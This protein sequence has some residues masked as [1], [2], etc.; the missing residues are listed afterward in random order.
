MR[1]WARDWA[2]LGLLFPLSTS[3]SDARTLQL[4][5][6]Y[7]SQIKCEGRL[8]VSAVGD[9]RLVRLEALPKDLGCGVLLKPGAPSGRTNLILET[10]IGTIRRILVIRS[11]VTPPSAADLKHLLKGETE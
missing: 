6:G 9:D 3:A 8:L 4:F 5:P 1:H 7:I 10:S 11:M 2:W